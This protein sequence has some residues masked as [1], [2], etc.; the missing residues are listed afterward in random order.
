V[1]QTNPSRQTRRS[2]LGVVGTAVATS[3]TGCTAPSDGERERED[4]EY[5]VAGETVDQL[6]I[7]VNDADVTV[8]PWDEPD[9]QIQAR[10]YA[11]G[12]TALSDVSVTRE[13]V[14]GVL[15]VTVD[16][17]RAEGIQLEPTGGGAETLNVRVPSGVQIDEIDADDGD[18]A[19][20]D[21]PG[22]LAFSVDDADVTVGG[23]SE[24]RG[25][26]E[27][28]SLDVPTPVTVGDVTGDDAE[29]DLA[30][31]DTDGDAEVTT[32]NGDIVARLTPDLDAT[33]VATGDA[34]V[35]VDGDA[36]DE[37]ETG[38]AEMVRGR[39]GDGGP[40]LRLTADDGLVTVRSA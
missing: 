36:L 38:R 10:T 39:V 37:V 24:V 1:N 13:V 15:S 7:A 35:Q 11:V 2:V 19:V 29:I 4:V 9:V 3:L 30:V 8:E 6:S 34:E 14:D 21:V 26:L 20:G 22:S 32:D 31:A 12:E 28:G 40:E 33:V 27:D 23:V 17:D 16:Y 25:E 5:T 18:I